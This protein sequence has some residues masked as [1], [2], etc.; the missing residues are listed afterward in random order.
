MAGGA[1]VG[2]L[3]LVL[4]VVVVLKSGDGSEEVL[5]VPTGVDAGL[6]VN[7]AAPDASAALDGASTD[8]VV[9]STDSVVPSTLALTPIAP[10]APGAAPAGTPAGTAPVTQP[11]TTA[12]PATQPA[13]TAAPTGGGDASIVQQILNRTNSERAAADCNPLV[14]YPQL[15]STAQAHT[16][17]QANNN[18]MSHTGSNGS[19]PGERAAA[20][21]YPSRFVGENVAYGYRT[22][23]QVMNGWMNSSGHRANILRCGYKNIG[24]GY[25]SQGNY[26]TQLFGG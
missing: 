23:E 11:A 18:T 3:L 26:W 20:A 21:G 15:A 25:V 6:V 1:A 12:A 10:L 9:P 4:M 8:S 17:D 16:Q 13:T 7:G 14:I 19:S 24:I 2:F 5:T 22:A